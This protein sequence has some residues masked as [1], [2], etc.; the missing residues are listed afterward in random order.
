MYHSI[1]LSRS[2]C[3]YSTACPGPDPDFKGGWFPI[4]S[5]QRIRIR[6][7]ASGTTFTA[8]LAYNGAVFTCGFYSNKEGQR[9]QGHTK[10]DPRRSLTRVPAFQEQNVKIIKIKA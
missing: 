10:T 4:P 9:G 1:A 8:F 6:Q 3:V 2:G 5:L 7:I